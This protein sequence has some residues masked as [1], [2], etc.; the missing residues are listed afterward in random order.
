V[1]LNDH[2]FE[3]LERLNDDDLKEDELARESHRAQAMCGVAGQI[4]SNGRLILDAA[5]AADELPGV[6]KL[7]L[8]I[9]NSR[10]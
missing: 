2:L 9:G 8:L 3:Q 10:E 6:G 7:P 5:R 4:I 1:D